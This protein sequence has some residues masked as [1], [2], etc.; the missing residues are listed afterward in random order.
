MPRLHIPKREN[1]DGQLSPEDAMLAALSDIVSQFNERLE[2][3]NAEPIDM[4]SIKQSYK[5]HRSRKR[6]HRPRAE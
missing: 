4:I 2:T 5:H 6:N 1:P 3:L